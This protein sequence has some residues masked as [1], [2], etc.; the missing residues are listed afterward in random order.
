MK[1]IF[2]CIDRVLWLFLFHSG[3]GDCSRHLFYALKILQ[4]LILLLVSVSF[5]DS[6]ADPSPADSSGLLGAT[7]L[8]FLLTSTGTNFLLYMHYCALNTA[9]ISM[10][11]RICSWFAWGIAGNNP[12]VKGW[13]KGWW[14]LGENP[15]IRM[16][17]LPLSPSPV[18]EMCTENDTLHPNMVE[19]CHPAVSCWSW[20]DLN[21]TEP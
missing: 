9:S 2:P 13:M 14:R 7:V 18:R 6:L 20:F 5:L 12:E 8:I 19:Q 1:L 10:Q 4:K 17:I 15:F 16:K 3:S 21:S 11:F